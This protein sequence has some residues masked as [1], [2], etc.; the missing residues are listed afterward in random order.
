MND[1]LENLM[2]E[3]GITA[4]GCWDDMDEFDRQA[5][6]RLIDLVIKECATV[7]R[8]HTLSRN[9]VEILKYQG[10]VLVED[11]IID[12]FKEKE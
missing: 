11:A 3:S 9:G 8:N 6:E 1:K 12:Y 10:Q 4:Q 7:A 2:Y 5:I